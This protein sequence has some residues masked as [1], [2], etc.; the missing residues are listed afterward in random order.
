MS[1]I[2][3]SVV[4]DEATKTVT[5]RQV[6]FTL[7]EKD[8]MKGY[9]HVIY[10]STVYVKKG[11][12]NPGRNLT[13]YAAQIVVDRGGGNVDVSGA[14]GTGYAPNNRHSAGGLK[15]NSYDGDNG[16][17][18]Q[19]GGPGGDSGDITIHAG[20]IKGGA[21]SLNS[22]GGAGG[23]AQ[24][25]G[26][27]WKGETPP[28]RAR[29]NTPKQIVVGYKTEEIGSRF[30]SVPVYGW[31][32]DTLKIGNHDFWT[33][34]LYV[35]H[36]APRGAD[37]GN[38]GNAGLAGRPG[39]GGKGGK[40][41]IRT[42]LEPEAPIAANQCAGGAA[43]ESGGHGTPGSG[44]DGGLGAKFLYHGSVKTTT[45]DWSTYDEKPEWDENWNTKNST[46]FWV[47]VDH[48]DNLGVNNDYIDHYD[49]THKKLKLRNGSGNRGQ[50]GGYGP[51]GLRTSPAAQTASRGADGSSETGRVD[52]SGASYRDIP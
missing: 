15:K 32:G 16:F 10:A 3:N 28:E 5:I 18:G 23:R 19:D 22:K 44:V 17:D 30:V 21:V 49:G 40:V 35:T 36:Q 13:I 25:G 29:P 8:F 12:L 9:H 48:F 20:R 47:S 6:E 31:G 33:A 4:V 41:R 42:L 34:Y 1:T 46:T 52:M 7:H 50:N 37:G 24:D 14:T 38:G 51:S 27:G 2:A 45:I 39:N 26:H 43:G 11:F